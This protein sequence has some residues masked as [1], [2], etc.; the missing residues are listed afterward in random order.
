[1]VE[2]LIRKAGQPTPGDVHVDRPLTNISIAYLQR[3]DQFVADQV[4]PNI[5]VAKQSDKY[6]TFDRGMFFRDQMTKRAPSTESQGI[7]YTVSTDSYFADQWSLHHDIPDQRRSNADS[8]LQP[9]REATELLTHQ[10][11]IRK[12]KAWVDDFFKATVWT[13]DVSPGTKWDAPSGSDP[14]GEIETAKMTVGGST[15]FE[16]NTIVIGREVYG[17]LRNHADIL[18]RIK[19]SGGISNVTPAMVSAQLLAQVFEV[20]RVLVSRAV[21]NSAAEGATNSIGY[22]AGDNCLVCYVPMSPGLMTPSAGYTFSWTGLLGAGAAGMRMRKF[23]LEQ[24]AS[25]RVEID[26]AWDQKQVA[27]DLGYML[28]DVLT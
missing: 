13:T 14:V 27:A 20:D 10:A 8:P 26:A 9:D 2:I 18:D 15:G 16:P 1:M 5:P 24:I 4:F 7:N 3:S 6:F 22:V 17:A 21:Y 23:R 19:Y 11:M 12:E 28:Y 25:D